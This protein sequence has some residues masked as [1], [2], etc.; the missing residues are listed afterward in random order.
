VSAPRPQ[1]RINAAD[2]TGDAR[3]LR[4]LSTGGIQIPPELPLAA[5]LGD[6][7]AEPDP[8]PVVSDS[9]MAALGASLTD[10]RTGGGGEAL[11]AR[12][13]EEDAS[14]VRRYGVALLT[15]D[16]LFGDGE[17][18]GLCENAEVL[19][20]FEEDGQSYEASLSVEP[21]LMF[22]GTPEPAWTTLDADC[23]DA[24]LASGGD[25]PAALDGDCDEYD[26]AQFFGEDTACRACIEDRSGDY[27]TCVDDGDCDEQ[28]MYQTWVQ[29][30]DGQIVWWDE[31]FTYLWA[32]AP[33][34]LVQVAALG[35][36]EA[37]GTL[38]RPWDE[39]DWGHVL[40]PFWNDEADAIGWV[41]PTGYG[42]PE[43]GD[44][45][46]EGAFY[47][48]NYIR[49]V[50][51]QG[52]PHADRMG[53]AYK[54]RFDSG[55]TIRYF[56]AFSSGIGVLSRSNEIPD[57]N[58]D[59]Q[60]DLGDQYYG[61]IFDGFGL[62][63][64]ALRPDGTDQG[65]PD[66]TFARDYLG[67]DALKTATTINGILI[68]VANH[69]RCE[70]WDG[71]DA[72]GAWRCVE[73]GTPDGGWLNDGEHTWTEA[74]G[75]TS[76]T[77]SMVTL[78]STGEPD[79]NVPGGVVLHIAGSPWLANADWESC[80]WPHSFVPDEITLPDAPDD[81]QGPAG[82]AGSTYR[83]GKDPDQDLRVVLATNQLRN[84]CPED[85][86]FVAR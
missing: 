33:D 62:D 69:S 78:G 86:D 34:Y 23:Q 32:C 28:A 18:A 4:G 11:E 82:L 15:P 29:Y 60:S 47:R 54:T 10:A 49:E 53:Y 56:W 73:S 83:F 8:P 79:P 13:D 7:P 1:R 68:S 42:D 25:V 63:P 72:D 57:T 77:W 26:E 70:T 84:F 71:P 55:A 51:D 16:E 50:G 19:Y 74:G 5:R 80:D 27:A 6:L 21:Y 81:W 35:H 22:V 65:D 37:D 75:S 61:Y 31:G 58:A 41:A 30:E 43:R 59:G 3:A 66:D 76:L 36:F 9:P 48:A 20:D 38:P 40:M 52:T 67:A 2:F 46:G 85:E 64:Y 24:L 39:A 44:T 12:L 14:D 45:L 17:T